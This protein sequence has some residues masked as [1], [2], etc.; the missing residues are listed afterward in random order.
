[1]VG[2]DVLARTQRPKI[3]AVKN[4]SSNCSTRQAQTE[5][6]TPRSHRQNLSLCSED[7]N[8]CTPRGRRT[9]RQSAASVDSGSC[10]PRL[11]R[12]SS[13]QHSGYM[14]D[15]SFR[16]GSIAQK[17]G[18]D[19]TPRSG[20]RSEAQ[21]CQSTASSAHRTS[22]G[23]TLLMTVG[24][25]HI[26]PPAGQP[27][28]FF[29]QERA[30]G[31]CPTPAIVEDVER[32]KK[33]GPKRGKTLNCASECL[34]YTARSCASSRANSPDSVWNELAG[35]PTWPDQRKLLYGIIPRSTRSCS[36]PPKLPP[37]AN[38]RST[39]ELLW[40]D[41][42]RKPWAP[43]KFG[44]RTM[45]PQSMGKSLV[46]DLSLP[47]DDENRLKISFADTA[48]TSY[49]GN[50]KHKV[51]YHRDERHHTGG[52]SI[53]GCAGFSGAERQ[54]AAERK[55]KTNTTC[56]FCS[57]A[58][59]RD[60]SV[61]PVRSVYPI[62]RPAK[63]TYTYRSR[64]D[65][66][67]GHAGIHQGARLSSS[68]HPLWHPS[69][70]R[71]QS[72]DLWY[73]PDAPYAVT[74]A[75]PV[76]LKMEYPRDDGTNMPAGT[77]SPEVPR[78]KCKTARGAT[79]RDL[80]AQ[81][82]L[83]GQAFGQRISTFRGKLPCGEKWCVPDFK[84]NGLACCGIAEP[85]ENRPSKRYFHNTKTYNETFEDHAGERFPRSLGHGFHRAGLRVEDDE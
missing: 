51:F 29:Q 12:Q 82:C 62:P 60:N 53:V 59:W 1:M 19:I 74:S 49:A 65:V 52:V 37:C 85:N 73:G 80:G 13:S 45:H 63:K 48:D 71:S 41:P 33:R 55:N 64:N 68:S 14:S 31:S 24:N 21:S 4:T 44:K 46:Y 30:K 75:P 26:R 22:P 2:T 50:K 34:K 35:Y 78:R 7:S 42:G 76:H 20:W 40:H 56:N 32:A 11:R 72:A 28:G 47:M 70:H 54:R 9:C 61:L 17:L 81:R 18:G 3:G 38:F 27:S 8:N 43:P 5:S 79:I 58:P 66:F 84:W 39:S 67:G 36:L 69:E 83:P 16:G 25:E 10:T 23:D 77:R 57:D 15:A 6:D